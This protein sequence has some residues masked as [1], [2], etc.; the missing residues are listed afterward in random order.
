MSLKDQLTQKQKQK[1]APWNI[2]ELDYALSWILAAIGEH[3]P[4]KQNLIFKGGTCLKKCYFGEN[5][6]FSEDLDFTTNPEVEDLFLD[7]CM[8]RIVERATQL[9]S[10]QAGEVLFVWEPYEEKEPHP[11]NQRAYS[12]RAQLPWHRQ[13]LTK[14]KV[15]ISRDEKLVFPFE[16]KGIIHEYGESF[17]QTIRAYSLEEI[18]AEKFRGILQNQE[19]WKVKGWVRSR[20]RDFYDVWRIL[21][22][23]GRKVDLKGFKEGFIQKCEIKGIDFEGSHQFFNK[24]AYLEIIKSDWPQYLSNLT[25][26]LPSY[27]TVLSELPLLTAQVFKE[28]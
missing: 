27:E 12:L 17:A 14:I 1:N 18:L 26:G 25:V 15:E 10:E 4:A 23:F 28:D 5:Y 11:F 3:F 21:K 16:E 2:I 24:P 20:V 19:R 6:R 22:E 8:D 9:S 13:P 7:E